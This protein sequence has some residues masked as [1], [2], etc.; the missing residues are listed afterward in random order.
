MEGGGEFSVHE[1]ASSKVRG[2]S[3]IGCRGKRS[4]D[5]RKA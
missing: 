1:E 4:Q 2:P 5:G 3:R